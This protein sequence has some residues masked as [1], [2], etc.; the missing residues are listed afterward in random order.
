MSVWLAILLGLVQGVTEFIPVS[1]SGHLAALEQLFHVTCTEQQLL[2]FNTLLHLG[3]LVA[4]CIVC[5]ED[6]VKMA[7]GGVRLLQGQMDFSVFGDPLI[8]AT[9][10]L[11]CIALGTLPLLLALLLNR[12]I[13]PLFA[14]PGFIGV[15]MIATGFL[16]FV[17]DRMIRPGS[18]GPRTITPA[19]GLWI[20]LAQACAVLPGL[21]SLAVALAASLS[22]GC[23]RKYALR[24]SLLLSIPAVAGAL[25][26]S[27]VRCLSSGLQWS[28]LPVFLAGFAVAAV[29]GVFTIRLLIRLM[30][31]GKF[32]H[33]STYCWIAGALTILISVIF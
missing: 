4:V 20:G 10:Q 32:G 5:R 31:R 12:R 33:L 3:T 13:T 7:R 2:F 1:S 14:M 29:T 9:R 6:I 25:I 21:S 28:L 26:V 24:F 8:P 23:T 16:L 17:C 11:L 27:I 22:R 30:Q 18:K 19:D 15:A